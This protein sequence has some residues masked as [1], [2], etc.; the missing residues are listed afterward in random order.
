[1]TTAH[2]P[3]VIDWLGWPGCAPPQKAESCR[4]A[5]Q[6]APWPCHKASEPTKLSTALHFHHPPRCPAVRPHALTSLFRCFS[7]LST[8][9]ST[10]ICPVA[11]FL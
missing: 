11:I 8:A 9:N 7:S 10:V 6:T 4:P 3:S 5:N 2:E 1:M